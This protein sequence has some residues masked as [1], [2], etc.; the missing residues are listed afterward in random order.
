MVGSTLMTKKPLVQYTVLT[1]FRIIAGFLSFV[2][3][4]NKK[5]VCQHR[6]SDNLPSLFAQL[7]FIDRQVRAT[8]ENNSKAVWL[9]LGCNAG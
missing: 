1:P 2:T 5:P 6:P 4:K 9:D 3:M 7:Q 8:K